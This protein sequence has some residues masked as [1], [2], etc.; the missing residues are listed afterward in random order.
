MFVYATLCHSGLFFSPATVFSATQV[1][2]GDRGEKW[3]EEERT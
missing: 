3:V 2:T 1:H